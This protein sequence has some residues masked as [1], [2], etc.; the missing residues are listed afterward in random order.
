MVANPEPFFDQVA[1]HRP[2]P[3][4]RPVTGLYRPPLNN[5]PQRLALFVRELRRRAFG[6][7]SPKP[8]DVICVVPLEPPVHGSSRDAELGGDLDYALAVDVLADGPPAT[9]FAQVVLEAR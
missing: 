7:R 4:A 8:F 3:D 5:E 9:P 6:N 1:D 2:G